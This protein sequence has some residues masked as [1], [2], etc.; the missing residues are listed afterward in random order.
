MSTGLYKILVYG[1]QMN[2]ADAERMEGQLQA[3]GYARTEEM[4]HA[5][6]ILI[7]TCCVRETAE[8]KV[9][10]KIGEVKK[11]KERNPRLIFGIAGC[12]AQKEGDNLMRRAPHID[13]VLGTGKV[14]ELTRIIGEIRA[15]HSPVV[16][17]T[18]SDQT[19]AEN[20]PIARGGQFS[21]W[22]PIMYGCNN[23]CTYCIVPYVRG[24]ERSRA[25]EEIVAEVRRAAE[26]GYREVTLLGQNVNSYGKDHKQADFADL[27]QM[28]DAVDGIRRVRFMTSH[29]KDISDKL[30]ET[31]KNGAH[32]CEHIHLPVQYGSSRILR[33]MNRGYTVE[34]YRARAQRVRE[35]LPEASLTTDLIVGFPGE[36]DEDFA[37][38]L[39]FL[40]EMRYDA[41][42][43][44][45]YSKRSG[46]PAAAMAEQVADEVKHARLNA[47]MQEQNTISREINE[48][49][50]GAEVEVMVEGAS[51][52]EP[53]VWSGRTR[54]NK[55]VLFPHGAEQ[56]GDFVRVRITQ[57]QTWVLKGE[58]VT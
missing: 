37:E 4:T 11:L 31:I 1:C 33:A 3:A 51:K 26:E 17:V 40:R 22:V 38:M 21:A 55:I 6:V 20:L 7:N 52:N 46:T 42:Y 48:A 27:L 58:I 44:F 34:Q 39:S 50:A 54:T 36:T 45:L 30:I 13:F 35:M 53:S 28:V 12:M 18:L 8:D 15:E 2:I 16:D 10:G 5:D 19:I 25:P 56:A 57:P 32:I 47:L 23:F 49:L 24:R 43:T 14:Q 41:A 9:Y 29:P